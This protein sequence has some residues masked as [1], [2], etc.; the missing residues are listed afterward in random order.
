MAANKR[1]YASFS[2]KFYESQHGSDESNAHMSS[3]LQDVRYSFRTMAKSP[4]FTAVAILTLALG[5]GANSAIFSVVNAV[6]LRP[7]PFADSNRLLSI[8]GV[9]V[10]YDRYP[11]RIPDFIDYRAR[12]RTVEDLAAYGTFSANLTG[13]AEPHRLQGLRATGNLFQMLGVRAAI[14]RALTADDDIPGRP[15][16][17]VLTHG[18]WQRQFGS[19][20]NIC[21]RKI[22]LGGEPYTIIGVLPSEFVLPTQLTEIIVPLSPDADPQRNNRSSISFLR[23]F[24]RLKPGVTGPQAKEDLN[25]IARQLIQEYP[26][27]EDMSINVFP[28]RE[29]IVGNVQLMLVVILAAVG[30]VLLIACAN[31]ASFLLA[32]ASARRKELAIRAALG[33]TRFRLVRQLLTESMLLALVGGALG[34]VFAVWGISGLAALIPA[35]LPRAAE[36]H[37]DVRMFGLALSISVLSGL[38]FGLLPALDAS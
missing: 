2:A 8:W 37:V 4:V 36:I 22:T 28:L 3:L 19:D 13:E 17:A 27:D 35:N 16:V 33:G 11:F 38:L 18:L 6:L 31:M 29:E 5:I 34:G 10:N 14:G 7:L 12:N 20:G 21:G 1:F 24:G 30:M 9:R 26:N 15:K 23:V 25:A 32:K